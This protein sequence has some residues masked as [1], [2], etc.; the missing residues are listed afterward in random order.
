[1]TQLLRLA[2]L[3]LLLSTALPLAAA[4]VDPRCERLAGLK[5]EQGA[6]EAAET[7]TG[8]VVIPGGGGWPEQRFDAP[9]RCRVRGVLRPGKDSDIRFE[10][11]LPLKGW[12]GRL[13]MNG[14]GGFGGMIPEWDMAGTLQRGAVTTA[15]DTGHVGS[16]ESPTTE[17]WSGNPD[18]LVDFGHRAVH[19]NAVA[20]KQIIAAFYGS[21]AKHSYFMSCSNGGRQALMSAQRYPADFDGILAGAPA[22]NWTRLMTF[23][24]M[25]QHRFVTVPDSRLAVT[26][27]P[28]IQQATLA[29]CDGI[30]HV[31]D[32]LVDDPREC[33]FDPRTLACSSDNKTSC[34]TPAHVGSLNLLYGRS[35]ESRI[36]PTHFEPGT[37]SPGWEAWIVG[38]PTEASGHADFGLRF[39]RDFVHKD[40]SWT[41]AKFNLATD[42]RRAT[43][44]MAQAWDAVDTNLEPF[45]ARGGKLIM[46]HGWLDPAIPTGDSIGYFDGVGNRIGIARRDASSRLYLISGLGHC[47][48]G[49][50]FQEFASW[51]TN[52]QPAAA[53]RQ[54]D[55]ALRVWVENGVAPRAVIAAR[56]LPDGK[57]ETRP[58][59]PYPQRA[60][61]NGHDDVHRAESFSCGVPKSE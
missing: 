44:Q 20:A 59:C 14:N 50:G 61:W 1:M 16:Y 28:Q 3:C 42:S 2:G 46:Y 4:S 21:P 22:N 33:K 52:G 43:E 35:A 8:P 60:L 48:G 54:L 53:D 40:R 47:A 5:L 30:D 57:R 32:G 25:V 12:N 13:E 19:V 58:L 31:E 56:T 27:I 45:F 51:N 10:V 38:S 55:E 41:L 15:S 6:V 24:A 11:W 37:E 26:Q 9:D 34:L 39:F 29:A 7:V 17:Q 18:K 49:P 36:V 23:A